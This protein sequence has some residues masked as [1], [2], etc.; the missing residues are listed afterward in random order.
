MSDKDVNK[1]VTEETAGS[2]AKLLNAVH[3][4][5][6]GRSA[7]DD[8]EDTEKSEHYEEKAEGK[9][10]TSEVFKAI[11]EEKRL[12]TGIVLVPDEVDAHGDIYD[13]EE[14]RKA[15]HD[16]AINGFYSQAPTLGI[17]HL[18]KTKKSLIV[19]SFLAPADMELNGSV[20]KKG[21]W[22]ITTKVLSDG[23][24]DSIKNGDF[25]GFSIGGVAQTEEL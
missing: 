20:V 10:E 16:F 12:V 11:D 14:V 24:W 3:N 18:F 4:L 2:I 7:M 22:L 1:V 17:Q 8:G 5:M 23:L 9:V 6:H 21:T 25:T 19:E 13:E 15:A